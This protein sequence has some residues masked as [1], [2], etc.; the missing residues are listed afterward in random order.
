MDLRNSIAGIIFLGAPLQGSDP[1]G[2]VTW[3][4]EL[5][6]IHKQEGL[7]YTLLDTLKKDSSS[8]HDLSIKFWASYK[9]YD[10]VCF[11]ENRKAV[12]GP[13]SAQVPFRSS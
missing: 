2:Y 13:L 3:L 5:V 7:R 9:D 11:Y 1:A 6:R 8:L 12:Y 4:A 10:I